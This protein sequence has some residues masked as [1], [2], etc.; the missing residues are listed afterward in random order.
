MDVFRVLNK[1]RTSFLEKLAG[2]LWPTRF[3]GEVTVWAL[4]IP[5]SSWI[6]PRR[7]LLGLYGQKKGL[8]CSG[9]KF[10]ETFTD[11]LCSIAE[12]R[13]ARGAV[14][15]F[16]DHTRAF[17]LSKTVGD[18][19]RLRRFKRSFEHVCILSKKS[20]RKLLRSS[21]LYGLCARSRLSTP[22]RSLRNVFGGCEITVKATT[23]S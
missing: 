12:S 4:A 9:C 6:C 5:R 3:A 17:R 21:I 14:L 1:R 19:L 2:I 13:A 15:E 8:R 20:A 18:G 23:I 10:L 7:L 11:C 16:H 22:H